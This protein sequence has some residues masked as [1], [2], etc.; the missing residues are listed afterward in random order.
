VTIQSEPGES[1]S[2]DQSF[3]EDYLT[4]TANE[5]LQEMGF[6]PFTNKKMRAKK[7]QERKIVPGGKEIY[8][9]ARSEK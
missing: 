6:T 4:S 5:H 3:A 2:E 7:Y 1:S 9:Y 8:K